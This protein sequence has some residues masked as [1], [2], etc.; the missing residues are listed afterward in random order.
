MPIG[1]GIAATNDDDKKIRSPMVRRGWRNGTSK[2][3]ARERGRDTFE[4]VSW[5]E[6]ES[7]VANELKRVRRTF[8]NSAIYGGSY[9]WASAGTFLHT[10]SQIHRFLNCAGGYTRSVNTY[11]YAPAEVAIPRVLGNFKTIVNS[12]TSWCSESGNTELFVAFDGVPIKNGQIDS[13]VSVNMVSARILEA[14][15]NGTS[16]VNVSPT[17]AS[18]PAEV[19]AE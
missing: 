3:T 9:G 16:F 1:H 5:D 15:R 14:A 10:Q 7:L 13:G 8:G 4:A 18:M 6:A 12:T 19:N 2:S 11:S 17:R